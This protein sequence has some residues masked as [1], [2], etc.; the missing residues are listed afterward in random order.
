MWD[1]RVS[2]LAP[3]PAFSFEKNPTAPLHFPRLSVAVS[4]LSLM[5][6]TMFCYRRCFIILLLVAVLVVAFPTSSLVHCFTHSQLS[7]Q[8]VHS[9]RLTTRSTHLNALSAPSTSTTTSV[10]TTFSEDVSLVSTSSLEDTNQRKETSQPSMG[11]FSPAA[12]Y[13]KERRK[14]MLLKYGDK[15][16]PLERDASSQSLALSLLALSNVS[17]FTLSIACGHLHPALVVLLAIFPG[18]IFSLWTLQILHDNL[19]GSL[20]DKHKSTFPFPLGLG[21]IVVNIKRHYLQ[22]S[23]LFWGSMPSAFGYYLYLTYGHVT[24]HKSFGDVDAA[25]LKQLFNSSQQDFEDGDVLFVAH[26]M[27]LKGEVGPTFTLPT[28]FGRRKQVTLSIS[29]MGFNTWK[30]GYPIRNA[31][32]FTISFMYER[33]M[34]VINDVVVAIT[35][36]NY[37]FPN[38]PRQFHSDCAKY[39]RCALLVRALLYSLGG[40]KSIFFLYLS[41]TLWSIPPHPACAMFVT[42]HGSTIDDDT[43]FCVP[44]SSTYAGKWYSLLT[45][46]TNYHVEHHDFPTIPLHK[47]G[48]LRDIAPEFYRTGSNDN[49]FK[50]M[51]KAFSKPEFYACMDAKVI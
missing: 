41:E 3:H 31:L 30:E 40:W 38:K 35:G 7:L 50:I 37:F 6:A 47:L 17:L 49:V 12:K 25:S 44:S 21:R 15:I 42:N 29:K 28:L 43:G 20:L 11:V 8:S 5:S 9:A 1:E 16:I 24:H 2:P 33:F 32:T 10:T 19:H 18:S 39:C 13:H 14:Q 27:K 26:R 45:L 36:W 46:G 23:I 34:L 51:R 22:E 48:Q 4:S